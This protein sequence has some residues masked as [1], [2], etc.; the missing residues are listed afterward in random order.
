MMIPG[1]VEKYMDQPLARIHRLKRHQRRSWSKAIKQYAILE[2]TFL[3]SVSTSAIM[4][5][6]S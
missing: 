2:E 1:V 6:Q 4:E 5:E 3:S